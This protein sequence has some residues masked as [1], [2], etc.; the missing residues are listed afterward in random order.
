MFNK[1]MLYKDIM[2]KRSLIIKF[3]MKV[4][5]IEIF[6]KTKANIKI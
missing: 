2:S 6:I 3:T 1:S 5:V 4:V